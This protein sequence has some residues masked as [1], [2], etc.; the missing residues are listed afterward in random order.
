MTTLR[1]RKTRLTFETDQEVR[2]RGKMRP[3]IVEP[4]PWMCGV[5]LK[6]TRIR[7][8]IPWYAIFL[9]GAQICADEKRRN[10]NSGT[11]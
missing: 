1:S 6:G 5:R 2:Y 3:L 10:K 8:E 7:Y 11:H 4:T 9:K